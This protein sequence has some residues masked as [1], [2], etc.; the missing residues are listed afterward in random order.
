MRATTVALLPSRLERSVGI[1]RSSLPP[2][3]RPEPMPR[4]SRA[5]PTAPADWQSRLVPDET[6]QA[7]LGASQQP[8]E[9]GCGGD[10]AA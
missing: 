9:G 5:F 8:A 2:S 3:I 4:S 1:G 6:M 10:P 7:V